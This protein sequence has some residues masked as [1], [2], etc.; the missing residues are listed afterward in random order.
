[1]ASH[2]PNDQYWQKSSRRQNTGNSQKPKSQTTSRVAY[3]CYAEIKCSNWLFQ[4]PR[5]FLTIQ[6]AL[7]LHSIATLL[8]NLLKIASLRSICYQMETFDGLQGIQLYLTLYF[9]GIWV[10]LTQMCHSWLEIKWFYLN[11]VLLSIDK[12][13]FNWVRIRPHMIIQLNL[14]GTKRIKNYTNSIK[15]Y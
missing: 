12:I 5:L 1:M 11:T 10:S 8:L 6:S 15:N 4:V 13:W 14:E 7:F 2:P 9:I 3:L